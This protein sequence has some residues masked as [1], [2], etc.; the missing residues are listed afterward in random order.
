[1]YTKRIT[2]SWR[3]RE[4]AKAFWYFRGGIQLAKH[5]ALWVSLYFLNNKGDRKLNRQSSLIQRKT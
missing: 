4:E 1:M 2:I 5:F 3:T